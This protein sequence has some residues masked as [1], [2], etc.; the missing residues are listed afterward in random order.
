[1]NPEAAH[2]FSG[3]PEGKLSLVTLPELV[4]TEL[5]PNI[6]EPDELK[7][8]LIVLWRLAKMRSNVAPWVTAAELQQDAV[9][10]TAL[11]G[12]EINRRLRRALAQAVDRGTLLAAPW[13]RADGEVE[14]RYFANS[15][16]GRVAV[17]A[18][19][20]GVSP[21]R[22][23]V[24]ER[25]NIF[26][27]YEE[28]VGPLTSL[29]SEELMEAEQ[30]YPAAWIEEAFREAVR[31]NKR[32]WRYIRAILERWQTEGRDEID[33]GAKRRDREAD[34]RRYIEEAYERLVRGR[35]KT[36]S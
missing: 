26:S 15:P 21:R 28:N 8:T 20:E 31:A 3:F 1:M 10:S 11:G 25:P 30:T 24:E 13:R 14:V 7:V 16:K 27:L 17:D 4:Y 36:D 9:I 5:I 19:R 29:I 32:N 34:A 33:R 12:Q 2:H 23:T 6:D 18:M 22:A 35:S